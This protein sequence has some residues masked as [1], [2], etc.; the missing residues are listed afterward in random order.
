MDAIFF[1]S[2]YYT[3]PFQV[4]DHHLARAFAADGWRVAFISAPITPF[5]LFSS[6]QELLKDRL[7]NYLQKGQIYT[8]GEGEIHAYVPGA[9][10]VPKNIPLLNSHSLH[11]KWH[12]LITP[13]LRKWLAQHGFSSPDLLYFSSSRYAPLLKE[14]PHRQSLFRIVDQEAGYSHYTREDEAQRS[15][16]AKEVDLVVYSA[17]SL[18]GLVKGLGPKHALYLPNGVQ[19]DNF[20]DHKPP[21]PAEY[22]DIHNPIAVYVGAMHDWFDADLV[23]TLTDALPEVDFVLIGP[24][25]EIRQKLQTR[26]NLHLLGRRS[27]KELSRYLH[28]ANVGIIPFNRTKHPDLINAINPL[29]LYEYTACGLPVV[30]TRWDELEQ[31][32]PPAALCDSPQE[33]VSAVKKAIAQPNDPQGQMAFASQYNWPSQYQRL[34]EVLNGLRSMDH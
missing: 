12:R 8:I 33:F 14:I 7:R 11:Q 15:A 19:L 31:I 1:T 25:K 18:A 22:T 21:K 3:S 13:S 5:H 32:D 4:G 29:K 34:I 20:Q 28:H 17:H 2:N 23:N 30:A 16:L 26:K 6:K 10:L 9:W 27:Y 24:E